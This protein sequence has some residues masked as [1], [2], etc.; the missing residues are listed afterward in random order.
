MSPKPLLPYQDAARPVADRVTDLLVRMTLEEKIGQMTQI[1]GKAGD[2][3]KWIREKHVGSFLHLIAGNIP[4]LQQVAAESRLGIP[5]I[6]GIDAIHGHAFCPSA[7]VFPTQLALACSWHAGLIEAVGRITAKD[8]SATGIQWTFSPV[9]CIAR[10]LRWGRVDETFGEDPHL[11]GV[12]AEALI[13]GYQGDD[14][15]APER[16]LA[17]AKHFAGYSET[18][19]GR[20]ST[21]ADLS[22][23]KLAAF[24]LPPF[25]RVA[26]AGC[27]TFMTGYQAIDG[28]PCTA[29][30]WLLTDL[31]KEQWGL[32]GFVV[33]DWDNVGKLHKMQFTC[34]GP[35]EAAA[36]AVNAGNDMIM[37]TPEFPDACREA[38][39]RGLVD[40]A[41]LD[42]AC[43]RILTVKFKLGLFDARRLPDLEAARVRL[44]LPEDRRLALES[45]IE[46]MVLLK[47][48]HGRLPLSDTVTRIAVVGPNADDIPPQ[49]GD[50][51]YHTP[52]EAEVGAVHAPDRITTALQGIR[53]RAPAGCEVRHARGCDADKPGTEGLAEAVALALKSDVVIAVVGDT[54]A[55]AGEC[56]DRATLDLPGGQQALLEALHATGTPLVVVL[57][58]SKPLS[59]P[60]VD[61]HADAILEAFN[62]GEA[63]GAAVAAILFGDRNPGGKL[64]IS[65][66][67]HVGQQPVYYNQIPGWHAGMYCDLT[68]AE[69][70]YPFGFGLSY[71]TYAYTNLRVDKPR[72]SADD[73]V[74][75]SVDVTNTGAR[76]GVEIVQVYVHDLLAPVTWPAKELK[77][78]A[79]VKLSA[80]ETRTV[81]IALHARD[82]FSIVNAAAERVVEPGAFE[83]LAGP[84]SRDK[85]LLKTTIEVVA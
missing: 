24:F 57:I 59:I 43:R 34:A 82:A 29:N 4:R 18:Q 51:S 2:P 11:I 49:L 47:N 14:Y 27:A 73:T 30:R 70:L 67:Q 1:N 37:N 10:D 56:K 7:T 44:G 8:V 65:F 38:V 48:K 17:C 16:I 75:V 9:L 31:L 40:P 45:A 52:Q 64:P 36:V 5:L 68:T 39:Q 61:A 50:W 77:G 60:W 66:P 3:E 85:D 22:R 76:E 28:V 42:A 23:R 21:E 69:P 32:D 79:R 19:G 6:F 84:S 54:L 80:Q 46:S 81:S 26:R 20:D 74:T 62:P 15:N 63:G 41:C 12:L 71:T 33:T 78:F 35:V 58:N 53:R 55:Y 83:I 13:R 25:E 72:C